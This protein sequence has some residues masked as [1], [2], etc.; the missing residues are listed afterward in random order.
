MKKQHP[1][2]LCWTSCSV[3]FSLL[4]SFR[5]VVDDMIRGLCTPL[6]DSIFHEVR[7]REWNDNL[8]SPLWLILMMVVAAGAQVSSL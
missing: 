5:V 1:I 2:T 7:K 8:I 6:L 3:C 4:Y